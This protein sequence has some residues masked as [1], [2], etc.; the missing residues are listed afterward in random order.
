LKATEKTNSIRHIIFDLGG[1]LITFDPRKFLLD[2]FPDPQTGEA[3]YALIFQ[4]REWTDLDRGRLSIQEAKEIFIERAPSLET[5]IHQFDRCWMH[6]FHPIPETVAI[7][8]ELHDHGYPLYALSN[9]IRES[10]EF[11]RPSFSFFDLFTA[12]VLSYRIGHVKPEP[13]IYEHL[14]LAHKLEPEECL[15]IDDMEQN[16]EGARSAGIHSI[17]FVSPQQL[18]SELRNHSIL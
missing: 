13:Q 17:L 6:M 1:V 16:V 10:F 9:F 2:L 5:S 11:L 14:L 3:M 7:L 18:Q 8:Q 12:M 15:F 4:S